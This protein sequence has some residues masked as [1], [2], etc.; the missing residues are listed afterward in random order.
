MQGH[1]NAT[2][3]RSSSTM[4]RNSK[5]S[6]IALPSSSGLETCSMPRDDLVAPTTDTTEGMITLNITLHSDLTASLGL[7]CRASLS[8]SSIS[9]QSHIFSSYLPQLSP[10]LSSSTPFML[11]VPSLSASAASSS[12]PL[13]HTLTC[14]PSASPSSLTPPT[15]VC[16]PAYSTAAFP[17]LRLLYSA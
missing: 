9:K 4:V 13:S 15:H 3:E 2:D 17:P 7:V 12:S 1:R 8:S 5:N 11:I 14:F 16:H 6:M 10:L